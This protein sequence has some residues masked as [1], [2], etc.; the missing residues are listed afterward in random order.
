MVLAGCVRKTDDKEENEQGKVL[1]EDKFGEIAKTPEGHQ[2]LKTGPISEIR[3]LVNAFLGLGAVDSDD[4]DDLDPLADHI[5]NANT[6]E[7]INSDGGNTGDGNDCNGGDDTEMPKPK[8]KRLPQPKGSMTIA[9][10]RADKLVGHVDE[11]C[12]ALARP[13]LDPLNLESPIRIHLL[14][15]VFLSR[16]APV[17]E[18]ASVKNPIL[19]GELPRSWIRI[20]GRLVKA[21]EA[22]LKH[23]AATPSVEALDEECVEA[24]ATILFCAG[25]LLDASR[26]NE[27][28]RAVVAPLEAVNASL[29]C[30]AGRILAGKPTAE[31]AVRQKTPALM[32]K[33]RLVPGK[34]E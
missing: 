21:L 2:G 11:T 3:R 7:R 20:L 12:R 14:V 5:K 22:S 33:H 17:G 16:S 4:E 10:A 9:H 8:P 19:A 32:A 26:I 30:S 31:A 13:D 34:D 28:P 24:L 27:M 6:T 1:P 25:L 29:A 15:N 18:K 23:T